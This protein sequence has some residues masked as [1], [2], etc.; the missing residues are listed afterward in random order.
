MRLQTTDD[1][2]RDMRNNAAPLVITTACHAV[3][4][5]LSGAAIEDTSS[6]LSAVLRIPRMLSTAPIRS[7][8]ENRVFGH[9]RDQKFAGTS[10]LFLTGVVGSDSDATPVRIARMSLDRAW[11]DGH[12]P[13]MKPN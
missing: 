13:I 3:T 9:S 6:D 11:S 12:A 5:G 4:S 2:C 1:G 10:S 7:G 8:W